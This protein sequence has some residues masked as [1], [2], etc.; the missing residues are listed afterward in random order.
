MHT[1]HS[2]L[3]RSRCSYKHS[4]LYPSGKQRSYYASSPSSCNTLLYLKKHDQNMSSDSKRTSSS[5]FSIWY[6]IRKC[7]FWKRM[8]FYSL[9]TR[10][11]LGLSANTIRKPSPGFHYRNR[12]PFSLFWTKSWFSFFCWNAPFTVILQAFLFCSRKQK[13]RRVNSLRRSSAFL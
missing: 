7:S 11:A 6:I 10:R 2:W 13:T 1:D 8:C 12:Q 5:G 9:R 3:V 4:P